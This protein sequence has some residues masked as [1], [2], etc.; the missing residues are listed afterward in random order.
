MAVGHILKVTL[1]MRRRKAEQFTP[2][3]LWQLGF[4][5]MCGGSDNPPQTCLSQGNWGPGS[6]QTDLAERESEALSGRWYRS[7]LR[8][9]PDGLNRHVEFCRLAALTRIRRR[10]PDCFAQQSEEFLGLSEDRAGRES[11]SRSGRN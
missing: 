4:D 10:L 11:S 1:G 8:L 3:L 7:S 9:T 5:R 6:A 2:E